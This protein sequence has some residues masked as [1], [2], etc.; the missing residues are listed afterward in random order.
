MQGCSQERQALG[1]FSGK[2]VISVIK[3]TLGVESSAELMLL[4]QAL[5][6]L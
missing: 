3:R 1:R 4:A 6:G 2:V 5:C